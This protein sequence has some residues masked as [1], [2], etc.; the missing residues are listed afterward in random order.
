MSSLPSRRNSCRD[1]LL[2][3]M[4]VMM[5]MVVVIIVM[6]LRSADHPFDAADNAARHASDHAANG[7]ADRTGCAPAFGR[8]S[9]AT[10][11]YALG[12]CGERQCKNDSKAEQAG[13]HR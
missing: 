13:G 10:L 2:S 12:L 5:M 1:G 7:R 4:V 8:A 11:D 6:V 3:I 9:L